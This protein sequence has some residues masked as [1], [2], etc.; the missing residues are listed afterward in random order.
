MY[1][2]IHSTMASSQQNI[3]EK[4]Q[5]REHAW[6]THI[7]IKNTAIKKMENKLQKTD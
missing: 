1:T 3:S 7:R 6:H 5:N 2:N 4:Q